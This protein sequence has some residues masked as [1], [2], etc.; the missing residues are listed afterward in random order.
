ME[1]SRG[2][3]A[4]FWFLALAIGL[5]SVEEVIAWA[6]SELLKSDVPDPRMINLSLSHGS[7][8]I[9]VMS[10]LREFIEGD[11]QLP[12]KMI[13][14]MLWWRVQSGAVSEVK[15]ASVLFQLYLTDEEAPTALGSEI[16]CI[17]EYFEEWSYGPK[18]APREVRKFLT[19]FQTFVP[20]LIQ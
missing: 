16:G 19:R 5:A 9:D 12:L 2:E 18:A 13:A 20:T 15:A 1:A 14:G 10:A 3:M 6:D 4:N 8:E 11:A 7:P 17:E